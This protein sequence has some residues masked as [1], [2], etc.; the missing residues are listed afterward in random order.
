MIL[1]EG[2]EQAKK[3]MLR[4]VMNRGGST[5]D[6]F[7]TLIGGAGFGKSTVVSNFIRS[8]PNNLRIGVTAPTHQAVEVI[9]EMVTQ[10]GLLDR[11]DARTIHSALSL[12]LVPRGA[13]EVIMRD[14]YAKRKSYDV[15]I[16][17]ECSMIGNDLLSYVIE[18]V[19]EGYVQCVIFVGDECQLPPT[20]GKGEMSSTFEVNSISKLMTPVR[21]GADNPLYTLSTLL[22]ESQKY[23]DENLPR[24]KHDVDAEGRGI[25]VLDPN[26]F[27]DTF[28]SYVDSE[29]FRSNIYHARCVAFTNDCVDTIN[30]SV[31]E[32][33]HGRDVPEYIVGEILIAQESKGTE[34]ESLYR[35]SEELE[36]L[37]VDEHV[38]FEHTSDGIHCFELELRKLSDGDIVR[39]KT[40]SKEGKTRLQFLMERHIDIARSAS[41]TEARSEWRKFYEI[42]GDFNFFKHIYCMTI[43]KS[44]GSTF[45]HTFIYYPDVVQYGINTTVKQLL[46][47]GVTRSSHSTFFTGV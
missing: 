31:R 4:V 12:K 27:V 8:I 6:S 43:H 39:V 26:E 45:K 24:I 13:E 20:D 22:R 21:T 1:N 17:D 23:D 18:S 19:E 25:H 16:V 29:D 36:I 44:Q 15:L 7:H 28:F 41:K 42:K 37:S 10:Q 5:L 3:D 35:N 40:P 30:R 11:V 14:D 34:Y 9:T 47:T 46:Y 33:L 2:Q 38:C 32:M